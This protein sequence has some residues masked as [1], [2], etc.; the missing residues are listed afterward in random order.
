MDLNPCA[1]R[2][3][4]EPRRPGPARAL[5]A[6]AVAAALAL[7]AITACEGV[8]PGGEPP[9]NLFTSSLWD[10]GRAEYSIYTGVTERYGQP[11]PTEARMIVVKED[12]VRAT[13]VK[14]DS[15]PIP[16]K[17]VTAIKMNF[18]ADFLTGTY[19]YHQAV[20]VMFDRARLSPLKEV[21]A[22]HEL[23]GITFVR[24]GP[25]DGRLVHEAHSYWDGEADR[26]V[27]V[28]FPQGAALWWDALP[29]SLRLWAGRTKPFAMPV[30]LLPTQIS[31]QSPLANTRPVRATLR[32]VDVGPL[33][34]PAGEFT[35]VKFSIATPG[36][37]DTFWFDARAPHAML[38][39]DTH[40]GR[41]LQLKKSLRLD[42]WNHH[43]NGDERLVD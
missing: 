38:R 1:S 21:M 30:W 12:L 31:G 28:E 37:A 33:T 32:L 23:C 15:G 43:M 39:F 10:D 22:H 42:Y 7:P 40:E 3:A 35:S 4:H 41:S 27:P 8:P 34:V 24:V 20:T 19:T 9:D 26:T 5:L 6:A 29:V 25:V 36:G 17:T 14:S 11:R 18:S 16:G 2:A 13:L